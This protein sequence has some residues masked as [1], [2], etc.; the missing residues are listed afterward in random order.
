MALFDRLRSLRRD[1][2]AVAS[3]FTGE[4]GAPSSK[5]TPPAPASGDAGSG[6]ASVQ[7]P[8]PAS[9][10]DLAP[11]SRAPASALAP[12]RLRI[13]RIV[14]ETA[15][16]VSLVLEDPT[17]APITFAPGQFF[18]LHVNIGG[19]IHK[20]AYSASSSA[21][22]RSRVAVTVKRVSDGRVSRHLVGH[23][24]EGDPI[25]VLGPS[26]SFTP[27]PA[28]G[29]RLIVLVGGGS[30]ITPLASIARTL[31][32]SE[33]ETRVALVYGN[34]GLEDVIF[35]A[36]LEALAKEHAEG[37]RFRVRHVLE[38]PPAGWTGGTG[39]LNG[40]VLGRE[41]DELDD[42][43]APWA[44]Y[45]LC[46]PAPMMSAARVCLEI[47]G[48][49]PVRIREERFIS[50]HAAAGA[51]PSKESFEVTLR[52]KRGGESRVLVAGGKTVLEAALDA[53]IDMPFSCAV[54]GCGTCRVKV[55]SG[56]IA[57]DEPN[58]LS[59]EEAEQGYVLACVS[60][61]T[62]ACTLEVP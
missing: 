57:Q 34:A 52:M 53:A 27:P 7:V 21:L 51:K 28:K 49:A 37:G 13:A 10:A 41:L 29:A 5:T 31:L 36:E 23:A 47:R 61:P 44:D 59:E 50:A 39:K 12:R 40:A 2:A 30:G 8:P 9:M 54:G 14:R 6:D 3:T 24:H 60:R 11:V 48:V 33:P 1:L 20:R 26:G 18:T 45:Y 56:S 55:A 19:E 35:H 17:G 58:C 32:A 25:D 4:P 46:G 15:D 16:A 38:K 22:D 62:S 42:P 43:D